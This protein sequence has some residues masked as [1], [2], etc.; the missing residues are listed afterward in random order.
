MRMS[1]RDDGCPIAMLM[2]RLRGVG[3][4]IV[5]A[6]VLVPLWT[7]VLGGRTRGTYCSSAVAS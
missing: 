5:A 2:A 4:F 7:P 3:T 1:C 6:C